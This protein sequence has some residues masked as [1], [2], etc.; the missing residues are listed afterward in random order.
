MQ[1]SVES[2]L[3]RIEEKLDSHLITRTDHEVRLRAL[4]VVKAADHEDRLRVLETAKAK[5]LGMAMVVSFGASFL[6]D[7]IK[8]KF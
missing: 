1:E 2:R 8:A 7:I 6:A 3:V 4:E 5:L